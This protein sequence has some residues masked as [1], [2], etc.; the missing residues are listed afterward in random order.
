MGACRECRR[1]F[2]VRYFRT[3][4]SKSCET[5][6]YILFRRIACVSKRWCKPESL[7]SKK[8]N[9]DANMCITED[10]LVESYETGLFNRILFEVEYNRRKRMMKTWA[11]GFRPVIAA[12]RQLQKQSSISWSAMSSRS[13][14]SPGTSWRRPMIP[15]S[16]SGTSWSSKE[17]EASSVHSWW[18]NRYR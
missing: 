6:F 4:S 3:E 13:A 1:P 18:W 14:I 5:T 15:R 17:Q 12:I 10:K 8:E 16:V 7:T 11:W 9:G 2:Y